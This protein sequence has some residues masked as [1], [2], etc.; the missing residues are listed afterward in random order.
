MDMV[1]LFARLLL[2]LLLLPLLLTLLLLLPPLLL[3]PLPPPLLPLP[4]P[5]LQAA[6]ADAAV[7]S[8]RAFGPQTT[9]FEIRFCTAPLSGSTKPCFLQ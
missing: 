2:P 1:R 9:L 5:L 7:A 8:Y 6:V 3:L 4:L